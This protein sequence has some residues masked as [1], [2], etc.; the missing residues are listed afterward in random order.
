MN[1]NYLHDYF[2]VAWADNGINGIYLDEQTS[3]YNITGNVFV[4]GIGDQKV[5]RNQAPNNTESNN[6]GTSSTTIANAGIET[7]YLDIKDI[8]NPI[9]AIRPFKQKTALPK[10]GSA[11]SYRIYSLSGRYIGNAGS[12]SQKAVI[13]S[14]AAG[15]YL[16]RTENSTGGK[17]ITGMHKI[18][19]T[20]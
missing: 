4:N 10:I 19:I 17:N 3:G 18:L 16:I 5:H 8:R 9:T 11:P 14:Y 7:A 12:L 15:I 13:S 2:P 6:D 1:Y 20:K